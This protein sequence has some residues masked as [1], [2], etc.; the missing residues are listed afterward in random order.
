MQL[1][2]EEIGLLISQLHSPDGAS[3]T[4]N[5]VS[6]NQLKKKLIDWLEEIKK[7]E[8]LTTE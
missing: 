5:G 1:S 3:Y 8:T 6:H 4:T 7:V 2:K